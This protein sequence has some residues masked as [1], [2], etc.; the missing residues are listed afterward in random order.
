MKTLESSCVDN[1][2]QEIVPSPCIEISKEI[3]RSSCVNKA[4][5]GE[6]ST[7]TNSKRLREDFDV[8][9]IISDPGLRPFISDFHVNIHDQVRRAYW[10]KGPCQPRNH[11]F[12]WTYFG[13][14]PRRFIGDWFNLYGDWLEY[15]VSKDAAF[16]LCCYLFRV[17]HGE[18]SGGN[19]FATTEWSYW[20]KT[21]KL[22]KHVGAFDSAHNVALRKCQLLTDQKSHITVAFTKQSDISK[23][24][25]RTRLIASIDVVRF[26]LRQGLPF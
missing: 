3:P 18:Q 17:D 20:K 4:N 19:I 13:K 22:Q 8:S 26:L 15:S 11:Q 9:E 10:L 6:S 21:S 23:A 24:D 16:C 25:Y 2:N 7:F 5:I 1:A 14:D 12:K